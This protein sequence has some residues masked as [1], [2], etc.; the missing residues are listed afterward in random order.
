MWRLRVS[1]LTNLLLKVSAITTETRYAIVIVDSA[2]A[3]YRTD[4]SGRCELSESKIQILKITQRN[5]C[6]GLQ[7]AVT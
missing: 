5:V 3:L 6:G 2:T 1:T 7:E 4:Y